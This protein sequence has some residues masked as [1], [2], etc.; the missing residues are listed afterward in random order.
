MKLDD[1]FVKFAREQL[2]LSKNLLIL[3]T[4]AGT[5]LFGLYLIRKENELYNVYKRSIL[6][7]TFSSQKVAVSWCV[8]EHNFQWKLSERIKQLDGR[9]QILQ[10]SI[11]TRRAILESSSTQLQSI[12]SAKISHRKAEKYQVDIE[13]EK[14]VKLTKYL[15]F[16]GFNHDT[17]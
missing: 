4:A 11:E 17:K 6:V 8:A 13:L 1:K 12:I 9:S 5:E 16:K 14:C 2:D 10:N 7:E 3:Q 15:Q